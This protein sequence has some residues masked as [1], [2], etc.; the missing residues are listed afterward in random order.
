MERVSDGQWAV[1]VKQVGADGPRLGASAGLSGAGVR[2]ARMERRRW[3]WAVGV[4]GQ[5]PWRGLF[6]P[7]CPGPG[8]WPAG[9]I[10]ADQGP[11]GQCL[12]PWAARS[13]S[14]RGK[15]VPEAAGVRTVLGAE[16][17]SEPKGFSKTL[18]EWMDPQGTDMMGRK[19]LGKLGHLS[20]CWAL[21]FFVFLFCF[22]ESTDLELFLWPDAVVGQGFPVGQFSRLG[23]SGLDSYDVT[24][25][26]WGGT[27]WSRG[28]RPASRSV[29][30]PA[31]TAGLGHPEGPSEEP[32]S[33]HAQP[34][35]PV[36]PC[37]LRTGFS[38]CWS[39]F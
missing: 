24:L 10:R 1:E 28:C 11:H 27:G 5:V 36:C 12:R 8:P 35:S 3:E 6:S 18:R 19:M 4:R 32:S 37:W 2:Q 22:T 34:D 38:S 33:R 39:H 30:A 16:V 26:G 23:T 9:A 17:V 21:C 31:R 14:W 13:P 20:S 29:K 15:P 25:H 7:S